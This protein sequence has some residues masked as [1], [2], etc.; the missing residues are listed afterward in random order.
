RSG[1]VRDAGRRLRRLLRRSPLV[2]GR[3]RKQPEACGAPARL[4]GAGSFCGGLAAAAARSLHPRDVVHGAARLLRRSPAPGDGPTA[5]G[6][7]MSAVPSRIADGPGSKA[8]GRIRLVTFVN[9]FAVGGTERHV[10]NLG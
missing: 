2:G 3:E 1:R 8:D 7:P 4:P 6:G 5:G 9:G 10:V